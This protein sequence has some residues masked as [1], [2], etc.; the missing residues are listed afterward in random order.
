MQPRRSRRTDVWKAFFAP[1][2]S[3]SEATVEFTKNTTNPK[4]AIIV[5]RNVNNIPGIPDA[6]LIILAHQGKDPGD[7]YKMFSD[8][9]YLSYTNQT[10]TIAS[11]AAADVE[12]S[13]FT[14]S[15]LLNLIA[16]VLNFL[17][18]SLSSSLFHSLLVQDGFTELLLTRTTWIVFEN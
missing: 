17:L 11:I 9:P 14:D 12:V 10:T 1:F 2:L 8:I 18:D 16:T 5:T 3:I 6:W 15:L 4:A 7:S 13:G